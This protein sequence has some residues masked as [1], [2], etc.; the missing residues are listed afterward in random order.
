MY[1]GSITLKF[2]IDTKPLW[3][4]TKDLFFFR[5]IIFM[6]YSHIKTFNKIKTFSYL[7]YLIFPCNSKHI[8]FSLP[9]HSM[10]IFETIDSCISKLLISTKYL[11]SHI[12]PNPN[13]I[14]C[15]LQI[16]ATTLAYC[17]PSNAP[18]NVS[19]PPRELPEIGI[20]KEIMF[21]H[22]G[23]LTHICGSCVGN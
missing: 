14:C 6:Y 13:F 7:P 1:Y 9:Y 5:F 18:T 16:M 20:L 2:R 12:S 17:R 3:L 21:K 19:P 4:P 23:F 11:Y 10:R 15:S 22:K 8:I